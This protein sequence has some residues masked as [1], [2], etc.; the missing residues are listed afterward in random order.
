MEGVLGL[1]AL[2]G[3]VG[4]RTDDIE[5]LDNAARPAVGQDDRPRMLVGERTCRK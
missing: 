4:Q 3:R 1:T 2:S 5:K